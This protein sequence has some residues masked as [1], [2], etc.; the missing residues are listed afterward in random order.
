MRK[1]IF[2]SLALLFLTAIAGWSQN[3]A[4]QPGYVP[5]EKLDLFP[6]D[7]LSV[8]INIEGALLSLIAA[9]SRAEDP[10]FASLIAGLKSIKVRAVPLKDVDA[11]AVRSRIS[12][13]VRWLEDRGWKSMLLA[14]EE[15]EETHVY[16]KE[17]D[18]KIT[19]LTLLA[20][21]PADEAVV[22][23]IVGRIDPAQIGRLSEG[24]GRMAHPDREKKK[25]H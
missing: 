11:A 5:T 4:D 20:L 23:N 13:T 18:G 9:G 16:L 21:D 8:E 10:E 17:T 2:L 14:R 7:K 19:G 6:R 15:G 25:P 22:I 24:V 3:L 12:Q 1:I